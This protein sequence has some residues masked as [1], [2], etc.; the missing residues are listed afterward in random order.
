MSMQKMSR[1]KKNEPRYRFISPG[2]SHGDTPTTKVWKGRP[3][4][5]DN[6]AA[7]EARREY[8][9]FLAAVEAG[10]VTTRARAAEIA[11]EKAAAQKPTLAECFAEALARPE[12]S[13]GTR[14]TW[15]CVFQKHVNPVLGAVPVD[16]LDRATIQK[17]LDDLRKTL[18][19]GSTGIC[20]N[21]IS[22]GLNFA[23]DRG[24]IDSSPAAGVKIRR[25]N[26]D[27]KPTRDGPETL[28]AEELDAFKT[29]LRSELLIHRCYFGLLAETGM[30]RGECTAL[31]WADFDWRAG[32][33]TISRTFDSVSGDMSSP[34]SKNGNRS[35]PVPPELLDDLR[36]LQ[37]EQASRKLSLW[38][39]PNEDGTAPRR[40]DPN[41]FLR[42]ICKRNG[43]PQIHCHTLRHTI[44]S[45]ALA[46]GADPQS[47]ADLL[48]DIPETIIR[49]YVHSLP[50]GPQRAVSA[51]AVALQR[52]LRPAPEA[53]G[54]T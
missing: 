11:A 2:V 37:K 6:Y 40:S 33:V 20:L 34:K 26:K 15:D 7:R 3:E 23:V 13:Q 28:T 46:G 45:L 52:D 41:R 4:W 19:P 1:T 38:V 54:N 16:R 30:R 10:E 53:S 8:G 42:A 48:G 50:G 32:T 51:V 9:K 35:I 21:A 5:S 29:G 36:E 27:E 39:F 12:L 25:A 24:H 43:L 22:C 17:H 49:N 18:S 44:A 47:V 31:Q 14:R